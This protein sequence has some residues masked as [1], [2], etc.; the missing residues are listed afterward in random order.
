MINIYVPFADRLNLNGDCANALIL[1][2]RLRWAGFETQLVDL[3]QDSDFQLAV[4]MA[5][6]APILL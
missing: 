4:E 2:Q 6:K 3:R 1:Q 5:Q